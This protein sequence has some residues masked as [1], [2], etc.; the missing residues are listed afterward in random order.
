MDRQR[1]VGTARCRIC[2]A[3]FQTVINNLSDPV[4]VYGEWIDAISERE[5]GA[6]QPKVAAVADAGKDLD[7]EKLEA[8]GDESEE[9]PDLLKDAKKASPGSKSSI[10]ESDE[11]VEGSEGQRITKGKPQSNKSSDEEPGSLGE[12]EEL[13][14]GEE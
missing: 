4:D 12:E 10:I 8:S 11:D 5:R 1:L 3:G 7:E 2:E 14:D 9:L 6:R 13:S